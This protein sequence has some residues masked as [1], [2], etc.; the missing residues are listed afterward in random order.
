MSLAKVPHWLVPVHESSEPMKRLYGSTLSMERFKLDYREAIGTDSVKR[1]TWM[2]LGETPIYKVETE[3]SVRL[4]DASSADQVRLLKIDKAFCRNLAGE[5]GYGEDV[6][7]E[8]ALL[9]Q[10]DNYYVNL[11]NELPLPVYKIAFSNADN[12]VFYLNPVDGGCRHYNDN[13]HLR[14][15]LYNGLHSFSCA[16]FSDHPQWRLIA[17]WVLMSGGCIFSLTGLLLACRRK[18]SIKH[19]LNEDELK[20]HG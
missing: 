12:D 8:I 1:L 7:I 5:M 2:C 10:Y 14:K 3:R 18:R 20:K 17:M 11:R 6:P 16:F 13:T 15:W 9:E 4:I 19:Y